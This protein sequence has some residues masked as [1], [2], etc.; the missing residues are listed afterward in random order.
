MGTLHEE[1]F[2]QFLISFFLQHTDEGL[3]I[4][5]NFEKVY[6]QHIVILFLFGLA[7]PTAVSY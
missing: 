2:E 3:M 5:V 6:Y 7:T 1:H 4:H